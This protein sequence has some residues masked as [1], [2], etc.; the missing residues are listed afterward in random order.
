M[1]LHLPIPLAVTSFYVMFCQV[2]KKSEEEYKRKEVSPRA[3]GLKG[4][5]EETTKGSPKLFG[6]KEEKGKR[7]TERK[8]KRRKQKEKNR[9]LIL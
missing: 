6:Q 8:I 3:L 2:K 9:V 1:S 4:K 7:K 5:K